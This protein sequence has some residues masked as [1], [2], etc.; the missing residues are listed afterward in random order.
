MTFLNVNQATGCLHRTANIWKM[1][2]LNAKRKFV[3]QMDPQ[4]MQ[5]DSKYRIILFGKQFVLTS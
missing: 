1:H 2:R 4:G 5:V 3:Y